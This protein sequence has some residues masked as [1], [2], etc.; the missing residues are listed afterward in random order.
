MARAAAARQ[1]PQEDDKCGGDGG[2][3]HGISSQHAVG[4]S[5]GVNGGGSMVADAAKAVTEIGVERVEVELLDGSA[6]DAKTLGTRTLLSRYPAN[7]VVL[8]SA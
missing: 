1:D 7:V 4:N 3:R 5:T 8:P 2:I 6:T